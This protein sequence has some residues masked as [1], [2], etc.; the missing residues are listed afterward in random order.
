[1]IRLKKTHL[2]LFFLAL[3]IILITYLFGIAGLRTVGFMLLIYFLPSYLIIR[4]LSIEKDEKV[5]FSFF[6]G[7]AMFPLLVWYLNRVVPSLR[8]AMIVM[9]VLSIGAGLFINK[10]GR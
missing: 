2:T 5:F 4:K 8:V 7:I 10:G 1:M 6:I 9:F 3:S